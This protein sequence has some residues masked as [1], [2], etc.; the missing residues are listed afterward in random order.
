MLL[1]A[2]G[3]PKCAPVTAGRGLTVQRSK[4]MMIPAKIELQSSQL[5]LIHDFV[6]LDKNR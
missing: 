1:R 4:E 2:R 5:A 6:V 3:W